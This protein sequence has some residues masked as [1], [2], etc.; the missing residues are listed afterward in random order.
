MWPAEWR[1]PVYGAGLPIEVTRRE[2]GLAI[3]VPV[4]DSQDYQRV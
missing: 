2:S 3:V 4:I 1:V